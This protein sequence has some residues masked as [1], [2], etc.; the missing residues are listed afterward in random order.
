MAKKYACGVCSSYYPHTEMWKSER[1]QHIKIRAKDREEHNEYHFICFKCEADCRIEEE[2]NDERRN[3][4]VTEKGRQ[5]LE[6]TVQGD[7]ALCKG[8]K[9]RERAGVFKEARK[10]A[11]IQ[12]QEQRLTKAKRRE[13]VAE[14]KRNKEG[15]LIFIICIYMISSGSQ[16]HGGVATA[17][18]MLYREHS[19]AIALRVCY[20]IF[21]EWAPVSAPCYFGLA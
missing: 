21:G 17:V 15:I 20:C 18:A 14:I 11:E 8:A 3:F 16:S 2:V 13:V 19:V 10:M 9:H 12:A 1:E 4:F 5:E 7:M 6:V